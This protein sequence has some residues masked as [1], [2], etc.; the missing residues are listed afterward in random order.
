VIPSHWIIFKLYN[1]ESVLI[2]VPEVLIQNNWI[3]TWNSVL[4]ERNEFFKSYL[5]WICWN[6]T[7]SE[8]TARKFE[9]VVKHNGFNH[10]T[11][12]TKN[13]WSRLF[14]KIRQ[15]L[16]AQKFQVSPDIWPCCVGEEIVLVRRSGFVASAKSIPGIRIFRILKQENSNSWPSSISNY[17]SNL[18]QLND[19][20]LSEMGMLQSC[21][22]LPFPIGDWPLLVCNRLKFFQPFQNDHTTLPQPH[23]RGE[24]IESAALESCT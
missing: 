18:E 23:A 1:E 21:L 22:A 13:K 17:S 12:E 5:I 20:I 4:Q 6:K 15:K 8:Y 11:N 9:K 2:A 10:R 19:K 16:L 7:E 14:R 24:R 3:N